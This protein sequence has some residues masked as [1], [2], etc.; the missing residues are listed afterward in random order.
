ML[1]G[2]DREVERQRTRDYWTGYEWTKGSYSYW[3]VGQYTRF[4]GAEKPS[5][6]ATATS[7]GE[8]T[9]QDFQGY[10]QG[11][12]ETG[13]R[14]ASE[15]LKRLSSRR[16]ADPG[17]EA[18]VGCVQV[19]HPRRLAVRGAKAV[20]RSQR[21]RDEL[22]GAEH[23]G[24]VAAQE[25]DGTVGDVER[26]DVV[27]VRVQVDGERSFELDLDERELRQLEADR[28]RAVVSLEPLAFAGACDDG[29]A[30]RRVVRRELVVIGGVGRLPRVLPAQV[31]DEPPRGSVHVEQAHRPGLEVVEPVHDAG[32]HGDRVAGCER[33]LAV[34]GEDLEPSLE[35]D[36][37]VDVRRVEVPVGAARP[38]A[39]AGTRTRRSLRGSASTSVREPFRS[40]T[41][42]TELTLFDLDAHRA[43]ARS[44]A[45]CVA[46]DEHALDA[47]VA[48]RGLEPQ[49]ASR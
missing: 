23:D 41:S 46:L 32:R 26:V 18:G 28:H 12:V 4:S 44:A 3:K 8:H 38:A 17:C 10:L 6:A 35:E 31:L 43:A 29:I 36:E 21:R 33:Q 37:G 40:R 19:Q 24:V 5:R 39:R 27:V 45:V 9:S 13:E 14:A 34:R 15:I 16:V 42:T 30:A 48:G 1:P 20:P 25:L 49:S 7:A 11:A 47:H 2:R 22:A